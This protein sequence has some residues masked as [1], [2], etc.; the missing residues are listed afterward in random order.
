MGELEIPL[1]ESELTEPGRCR[2]RVRDV[3]V[4]LLCTCW[5]ITS[6]QLTNLS[7]RAQSTLTTPG[8]SI[9]AHPQLYRDALPEVKFFC[10]LQKLLRI[11]GYDDFG[12]R[13][14]AAPNARRF[15]RQLSACINF[16]KFRE[17]NKHTL[18]TVLEDRNEM[19]DDLEDLAEKNMEVQDQLG[20]VRED[21]QSKLLEREEA[22]AECQ[23][24]EAE[25]AEQNKI[26]SSIRQQNTRLQKSS[27]ELKDQIANLSI[28]LRELQAEE[29]QLN[30]EVVHAP[31]S[32]KADVHKAEQNLDEVKKLIVKKEE[33]RNILTKKL[34]N[35]VKGE[36][37]VKGAVQVM[38]D[39]DEIVQEYEIAAEDAGD[40]SGNVDKVESGLEKKRLTKEEKEI[41]LRAVE[42]QQLHIKAKLTK[43]LDATKNELNTAVN[44]LG[45]VEEERLEGIA[46]MEAS[47]RRV[48]ELQA[49]IEAGKSQTE[50]EIR[51]RIASFQKYERAYIAMQ[52]EKL[53]GVICQ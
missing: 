50:V 14:L 48:E 34:K 17:D 1:T 6:N 26:Q 29:R 32:I 7:N 15:R 18:D 44:K 27:N 5:G 31:D 41:E 38:G 36:E 39:V 23:E 12:L 8:T 2:E 35:A 43:Q 42:Q 51:K 53:S 13:D 52:K 24:M 45:L 21:H 19:F 3:F 30:K 49:S 47:Q 11:C 46:K 40:V 33:E 4:Q 25:I 16:M 22:E 28:A 10:L 20:K 37:C 9:S